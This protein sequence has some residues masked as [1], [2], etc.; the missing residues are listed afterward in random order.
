MCKERD[1]LV[2]RHGMTI[3]SIDKDDC[4]YYNIH[5]HVLNGGDKCTLLLRTIF[6]SAEEKKAN[7]QNVNSKVDE[8]FLRRSHSVFC[9]FSCAISFGFPIAMSSLF[10]ISEFTVFDEL[11]TL[12]ELIKR[13]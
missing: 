6:C 11:D 13:S 1:V 4:N 9:K 10:H 8:G 7:K 3:S 12:S 2:I 5:E